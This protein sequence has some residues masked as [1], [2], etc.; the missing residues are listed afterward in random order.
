MCHRP[1]KATSST[2]PAASAE[3]LA[4]LVAGAADM[5]LVC[6]GLAAKQNLK[7]DRDWLPVG[8]PGANIGQ[9]QWG[10]QEHGNGSKG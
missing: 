6:N 4:E 9:H 1:A 5:R 3:T 8:K 10:T 2:S 7:I